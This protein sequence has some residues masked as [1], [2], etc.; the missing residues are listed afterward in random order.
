MLWLRGFFGSYQSEIYTEVFMD[1]SIWYLRLAVN[2]LPK[3][4]KSKMQLWVRAEQQN[5]DNWWSW[6]MAIWKFTVLFPLIYIWKV[7]DEKWKI[8]IQ[9]L[10][11]LSLQSLPLISAHFQ[12]KKKMLYSFQTIF[13][14]SLI[15]NI[16]L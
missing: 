3:K 5:A 2:S 15:F 7:H 4:K 11:S 13:L 8:K 6:L 9:V 14:S 1:Q 16:T 10:L 12:K